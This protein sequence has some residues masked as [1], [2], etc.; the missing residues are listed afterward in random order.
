[1]NREDTT[2]KP[3]VNPCVLEGYVVS[4]SYRVIV[5]F[6]FSTN[7]LHNYSKLKL[8][9]RLGELVQLYHKKEWPM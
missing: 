6:Y 8:K 7:P 2:T 3:G 4:V 9:D 1:M 5:T